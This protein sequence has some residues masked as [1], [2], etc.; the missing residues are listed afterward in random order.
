MARTWREIRRQK[1]LNE[2]RVETYRRLMEA[3]ARLDDVRRRCGVSE[4][5][6]ADALTI[7]QSESFGDGREGEDYL[8]TLTRY[9]GLL[10]GRLELRAVFPEETVTLLEAPDRADPPTGSRGQ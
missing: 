10:G 7:D 3:E 8:A 2:G 5:A 1:P 9:V 4:E 6:A